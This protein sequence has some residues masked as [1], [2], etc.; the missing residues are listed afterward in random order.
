MVDTITR[1]TAP[2]APVF[3]VDAQRYSGSPRK[4]FLSARE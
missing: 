2:M 1:Q 4:L 3:S